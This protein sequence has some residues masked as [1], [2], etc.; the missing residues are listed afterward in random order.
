[1]PYVYCRPH[2]KTIT[3]QMRF[4]VRTNRG[5]T[6]TGGRT[7]ARGEEFPANAVNVPWLRLL[8]EQMR[9]D[10][11][12]GSGEAPAPEQVVEPVATT[13]RPRKLPDLS[14]L[15]KA[16]LAALCKK[17]GLDP[18]GSKSDLQSRL[19]ALVG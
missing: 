7:F 1:M 18:N 4:I 8:Y 16:E 5:V 17:H 10:L 13:P 11:M 9:I 2:V 14:K 15:A 12:P 19:T 6:V 3:P